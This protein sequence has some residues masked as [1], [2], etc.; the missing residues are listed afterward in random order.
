LPLAARLAA[1]VRLCGNTFY[2]G[3]SLMSVWSASLPPTSASAV[4]VAAM[5]TVIAV[6]LYVSPFS[7][8][9]WRRMGPAGVAA[10]TA[11]M[12]ADPR[13]RLPELVALVTAA[14]RTGTLDDAARLIAARRYARRVTAVPARQG[15]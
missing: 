3:E 7:R 13:F 6:A 11:G 5:E 9:V 2:F 8:A 10:Y 12:L 1:P 4:P 15:R 14:E